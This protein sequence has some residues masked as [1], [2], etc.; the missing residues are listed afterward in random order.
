VTRRTE[1]SDADQHGQ[2]PLKTQDVALVA[3]FSL[4]LGCEAY[5]KRI[6]N[7]GRAAAAQSATCLIHYPGAPLISPLFIPFSLLSTAV[8]SVCLIQR[9]RPRRKNEFYS[10]YLLRFSLLFHRLTAHHQ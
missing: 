4:I 7:T 1:N 2:A 8:R 6:L 9:I 10:W 5:K 3:D